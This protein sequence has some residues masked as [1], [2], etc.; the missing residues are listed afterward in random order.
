MKKQDRF[1]NLTHLSRSDMKTI[2]GG[3]NLRNIPGCPVKTCLLV[4]V[5][6]SS[7]GTFTCSCVPTSPG[8][9]TG[10]CVSRA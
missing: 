1:Q 5:Q 7:C 6:R 2:N 9:I 3:G 10:L 8:A 4:S